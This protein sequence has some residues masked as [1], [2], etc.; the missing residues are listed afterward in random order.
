MICMNRRYAFTLVE[1]AV[2]FVLVA[3]VATMG[4]VS[5]RSYIDAQHDNAAR[6]AVESVLLSQE[7][8][9][10]NRS[11]V[12]DGPSQATQIATNLEFVGAAFAASTGKMS[13]GSVV[14]PEGP[15]AGHALLSKSG[16]CVTGI[17]NLSTVPYQRT[18]NTFTVTVQDPCTALSVLQ[19]VQ[20][21][22]GQ[23]QGLV[24]VPGY[25]T[26]AL[27]WSQPVSNGSPVTDYVVEFAVDVLGPWTVFVDGVT[28]HTAA[29]V[30]GLSPE[31]T[32]WFRVSA[33]NSAGSGPVSDS[34][35]ATTTGEASALAV[36]NPASQPGAPQASD[37]T[38]TSMT[39]TWDAP[40]DDGG[41]PVT[42]YQI[43]EA[44]AGLW[45]TTLDGN[46][47]TLNI[48]GLAAG[49]SY[50]WTI[51]ACNGEDSCSA[52]SDPT[53]V[54]T[55]PAPPGEVVLSDGSII[56]DWSP[57]PSTAVEGY[58]VLFNETS[59]LSV[60]D[61]TSRERFREARESSTALQFSAATHGSVESATPG[62]AGRI[63]T[64]NKPN[65]DPLA[66]GT[67]YTFWVVAYNE[68]GESLPAVAS[69][70]QQA[71]LSLSYAGTPFFREETSQTVAPT[72]FG[73]AGSL[74]FTV[75]PT[76][77]PFGVSFN[78]STGVFTGPSVWNFSVSEIAAG[79]QHT[80]AITTA[81]AALCWGFNN[82]G[83]LGDGTT[84]TRTTPVPVVGLESGV[85]KIVAGSDHTCAIRNGGAW[86]WGRG[87]DGRLGNGSTAHQYIP[88]QVTNFGSGVSDISTG[89]AGQYRSSAED[90]PQHTCAVRNGGA[91]CWGSN[92]IGQLG[93][94]NTNPSYTPIAV[95]NVTGFTSTNIKAVGV[96]A[97][98]SCAVTTSNAAFCWG[99]DADGRLGDGLTVDSWGAPISPQPC[100]SYF[101]K[102]VVGY[103][104]GGVSQISVG[105]SHSCIV[106]T[107]NRVRCWGKGSSGELGSGSSTAAYS[108]VDVRILNESGVFVSLIS[109][110]QL[111]AG[112][113]H[114]CITAGSSTPTLCWGRGSYGQLGRGTTLNSDAAVPVTAPSVGIEKI[115][116][117]GYHTC[118]VSQSGEAFC[119]GLNGAGQ[120]GDGTTVSANTPQ[121]V[122]SLSDHKF[123]ATV[124]V[125]V[126]D[127]LTGGVADSQVVLSQAT[128]SNLTL[129]YPASTLSSS[130][131]SFTP[132]TG[133]LFGFP[134][135]FSV[136]TQDQTTLDAN[137]I[138]LSTTTG[139]FSAS[140]GSLRLDNTFSPGS[141]SNSGIS[142]TVVQP[143]GKI[144]IGGSFT[145]YDNVSVN[146]LA[147]LHPNGRLDT[148]FNIGTGFNHTVNTI[149]LDSQ[150][151][152]LVGGWFSSYNGVEAARIVRLNTDGSRD[153][154]FSSGS[155]TGWTSG[156][157]IHSILVQPDGKIV[158]GGRFTRYNGAER[159]MLARANTDGSVDSSFNP[160][161]SYPI[162]TSTL[163]AGPD[164][165][166]YSI[167]QQ[168]DGKLIIGGDFV[169]FSGT[170]NNRRRIAR[171]NTN[172]TRDDTF[173]PGT[174]F[175]G[176]VYAL[177]L[178]S[179]GK[180]VAVG[181]FTR[182]NS[183]TD[184]RARVARINSNASLDTSFNPGTGA[185]SSITSFPRVSAVALQGDG[186]IIIGGHF[187]SYDGAASSRLARLN[188]NGTRDQ[189]FDV[190]S[191]LVSSVVSPVSS[192]IPLS[193]GLTLISGGFSAYD[194]TSI[195]NIA[196]IHQGPVAGPI[197]SIPVQVTMS[198][199]LGR[200]V[201]ASITVTLNRS[202]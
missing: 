171:V 193:G 65:G 108:P 130:T 105:H 1:V 109:D 70:T 49:T 161:L 34:V 149:A 180:I 112:M 174:G 78:E 169:N 86:C 76:S 190:G 127:A 145:S 74:S 196:R 73:G 172:G 37:V 25:T 33:V 23:V 129:S 140:F 166:V 124:T 58:R 163:T 136:R 2:T 188:S 32:Y 56:V 101:P 155:L 177:A 72:V 132:V 69:R 176:T 51:V 119:W 134:P 71:P 41:S 14:T 114:S 59:V 35:E 50:T 47:Q 52:E 7:V 77:L 182:Y 118:S 162:G 194:G 6:T 141:S 12:A 68:S 199:P 29:V 30:T 158:I 5:L 148:S 189:S 198:D 121:P 122:P 38:E 156:D 83:Q 165:D 197:T 195:A 60:V 36:F 115:S 98:H 151:K 67:S 153:V 126:T 111:S 100:C 179:D 123:P 128:A 66:G 10:V 45:V 18:L 55:L 175:N 40:E 202:S 27:S 143:D 79:L 170:D 133:N 125:T 3:A 82:Y 184:N 138:R 154:T 22:P 61:T 147:R 152:I 104:A 191:G 96:G 160:A 20:A 146:R 116:A 150:G 4:T 13:I 187:D 42:S 53:T 173:L 16:R 117:G 144:L 9:W 80:C 89:P 26:V 186:K 62:R 28:A 120:R 107:S 157:G 63:R 102:A 44:A 81:G 8:N 57:S 200:S 201:T 97:S 164:S 185:V 48:T 93:T 181:S 94:G 110:G 75:T 167:V 106:D 91:W 113:I 19:S 137:G 64:V 85:E 103:S 135:A 31:T 131:P 139:E 92:W 21:A 84:T 88:V 43:Y 192:I 15:I 90:N 95:M 39:L 159:R 87:T 168:P 17:L 54:P 24:A 99:S 183:T 46:T 142:A 178:Q 11:F